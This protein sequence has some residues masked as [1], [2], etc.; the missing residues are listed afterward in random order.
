[1]EVVAPI[2]LDGVVFSQIVGV[3][4][5]VIFPLHQKTR[6]MACKN[7]IV[8]YH[9]MG[10]PTYLRKEEVGKPNQNATQL[11]AKA[12]ACVNDDLRTDKLQKSWDFGLVPGMLTH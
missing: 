10:A 8:E 11:C 7:T 3:S 9:P 5:F 6:K 12:Q 2:S 1:V 4:A